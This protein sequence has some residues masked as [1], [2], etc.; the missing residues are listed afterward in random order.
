MRTGGTAGRT[1]GG[2][3]GH[4]DPSGQ[5]GQDLL[6]GA[7]AAGICHGP[8]GLGQERDGDP[9]GELLGAGRGEPGLNAGLGA[10]L[11][12]E[13]VSGGP[14]GGVH[15]GRDHP[16]PRF[17]EASADPPGGQEGSVE[18]LQLLVQG[19]RQLQ[20]VYLGKNESRDSEVKGVRGEQRRLRGLRSHRTHSIGHC[21]AHAHHRI[22]N[23]SLKNTSEIPPRAPHIAL[24]SLIAPN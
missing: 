9:Q 12:A 7:G 11:G 8:P 10:S 6:G 13:R 15:G 18:S 20:Q 24:R 23:S 3:E 5:P 1:V 19:M 22:H 21:S 2:R 17:R 4:G 16:G 14:S